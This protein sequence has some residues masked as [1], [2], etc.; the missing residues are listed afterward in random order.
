MQSRSF[1]PPAET[2]SIRGRCPV[3]SRNFSSPSRE[4]VV[5]PVFTKG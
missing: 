2:G 1:S 4:I 5:V 3:A